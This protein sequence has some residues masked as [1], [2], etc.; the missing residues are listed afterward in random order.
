MP[1]QEWPATDAVTVGLVVTGVTAHQATRGG[2]SIQIG[3]AMA[4]MTARMGKTKRIVI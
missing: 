1:L 2:A 4:Q 3:F